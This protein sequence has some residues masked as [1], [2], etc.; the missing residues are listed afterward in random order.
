MR[1]KEGRKKSGRTGAPINLQPTAQP[2]MLYITRP[3]RR[4][5][6]ELRSLTATGYAVHN[7]TKEKRCAG[8]AESHSK[9]QRE[10]HDEEEE[11]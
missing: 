5:V 8:A 11:G 3:K 2:D 7:T 4:D 10:I 1:S 9:G 6:R